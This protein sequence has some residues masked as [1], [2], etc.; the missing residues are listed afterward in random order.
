LKHYLDASA[1]VSLV[2][3]DNR[4]ATF[5]ELVFRQKAQLL[6]SDFGRAEFASA[7]SIRVREG[8]L[9]KAEAAELL[10]WFD[11][12]QPSAIRLVRM[13]SSDLRD[14]TEFVQQ[15]EL[16]LR[17]PD[18]LHIAV[19]RRLGASLVT[20]DRRQAAAAVSLGLTVVGPD[21]DPILAG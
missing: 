20:F 21:Q 5:V 14:A 9:P 11:D 6:M 17:A 19:A 13:R 7:V 2:F 16:K 3:T 12:W 15:F 18:A 8:S 1:L 4:L 10:D